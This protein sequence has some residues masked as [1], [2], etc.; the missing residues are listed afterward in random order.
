MHNYASEHGRLPPAVVYGKHGK[1]L[2]S[3]RVLILPYIEQDELFKQFH[4][5]EPWDSPHNI[6]LL[7]RMPR[8]FGRFDGKPTSEPDTTFYQVFTGKHTA[9]ESLEG[10]PLEDFTDGTGN[11]FL[12]VEAGEAVPWT[13]PADLAYSPDHPLPK[14]GGILRDGPFR[15]ALADG[16][17]RNVGPE[18]REATLRAAITRN[19]KDELGPEW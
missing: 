2:L 7:P 6:K 10:E 19:G 4:L 11:T 13:K 9:F 14:F 1:P 16:S 18:V 5:D 15:A 12:I 17:V 8:V 3:W